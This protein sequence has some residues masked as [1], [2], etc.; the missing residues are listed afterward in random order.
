MIRRAKVDR[1]VRFV[2]A[3]LLVS[4]LAGAEGQEPLR[5]EEQITAVD[6]LIEFVSGKASAPLTPPKDLKLEEL[7]VL[8]DGNPVPLV[9]LE[10]PSAPTAERWRLVVYFDL[11]LASSRTVRWAASLLAE[12]LDELLELGEVEIVLAD[13]EP[14]YALRATDDA[15]LLD[16]TLSGIFLHTL[17]E[18]RLVGLREDFL[19]AAQGNSKVHR[20]PEELWVAVGKE[21][22]T[23]R[24]RQDETLNWL[25]TSEGDTPRRALFF[26][27]DGFDLDP[28]R[29]YRRTSSA[30]SQSPAP[31]AGL[32][33][34]A[35]DTGAWGRALA[36][37]GWTMV[38]LAPP[39]SVRGAV[40]YGIQWAPQ[41]GM[42]ANVSLRSAAIWFDRNRRPKRAEAYNELGSTLAAQG[43][44]EE[45][46][47][48]F[49][50]SV[51]H[52]YD[53]RKTAS[54]QAVALANLAD[55]L[56]VQGRTVEARE[57]YRSAVAF[58]PGLAAE[59]PFTRAAIDEPVAPLSAVAEAT[60]G[61]VVRDSPSLDVM[62]A[63][64]GGRARVTYQ[65]AG[66]PDGRL[67][68]IEARWGR[69]GRLVTPDWS[70]SGTVA[71]VGALRLRRLFRGAW[72]IGD[73]PLDLTCRE[74]ASAAGHPRSRA[75]ELT[76]RLPREGDPEI[77]RK[78]LLRVTWGSEGADAET[79]IQQRELT[80][81]EGT[82]RV[83]TVTIDLPSGHTGAGAV[84][85]EIATGVW[86][87]DVCE[88]L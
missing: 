45:A 37:Y 62:L 36:A 25:L 58:D 74:L 4:T 14:R 81:E 26:V 56:E 8:R 12:H 29:F 55:V 15:D 41:S 43:K 28:A 69:Q 47:E 35:P 59:Y 27:S 44:L 86:G 61:R 1:A 78:G 73:L 18:D 64:L 21:L 87:A 23:V 11:P 10:L 32:P 5:D 57:T 71:A 6:V 13:P 33:D 60:T 7:T 79:A 85:E 53:H 49:R 88:A 19:I 39:E 75:L 51:Y 30:E 17:G 9:G 84:V 70:R 31:S 54:R 83:V 2:A 66:P 48:A 52:Y 82:R 22:R 80:P 40:R 34:L 68:S 38:P 20:S 76:V 16:Q 3:T 72:E 24:E 63:S 65:V 50:K 46:E 42:L 77:G 67:H